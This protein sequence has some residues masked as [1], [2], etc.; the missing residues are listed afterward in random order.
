MAG[1]TPPKKRVVKI[2][3]DISGII[4]PSRYVCLMILPIPGKKVVNRPSGKTY[5]AK[6]EQSR[7][8][9][10]NDS[11]SWTAPFR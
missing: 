4:R 11:A 2:L 9:F 7:V 6:S 1:L 5:F 8:I 3:Q 10:Q